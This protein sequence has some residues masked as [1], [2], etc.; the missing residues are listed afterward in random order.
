M[1]RQTHLLVAQLRDRAVLGM[2]RSITNRGL[3]PNVFAGEEPDRWSG[4]MP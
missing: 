4:Q 2:V 3:G 1:G